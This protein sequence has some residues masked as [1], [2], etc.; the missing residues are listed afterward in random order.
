MALAWEGALLAAEYATRFNAPLV[1]LTPG[2]WKQS[3][4]KP[5]M[6][7]RLWDALHVDERELLGG[8]RIGAVIRVACE[9]GATERWA[10][11]GGAYYPKSF[12]EHNLLDAVALT[13]IFLG[14]FR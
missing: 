9:K 4:R 12:V 1:Q 5:Q 14:A 13:K 11:A 7:F 10:K 2:E 8:A 3:Q 6:H